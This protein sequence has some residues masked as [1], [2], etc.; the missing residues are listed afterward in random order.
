M[1]TQESR[2]LRSEANHYKKN[3]IQQLYFNFQFQN[4]IKVWDRNI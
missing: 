1:K 3:Q 2:D 4:D